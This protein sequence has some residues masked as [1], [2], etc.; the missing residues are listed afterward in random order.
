MQFRKRNS[1]DHK[2]GKFSVLALASQNILKKRCMRACSCS[3]QKVGDYNQSMPISLLP[4]K[5]TTFTSAVQ[6][7]CYRSTTQVPKQKR[8]IE[9]EADDGS[10]KRRGTTR[11]SASAQMHGW[12]HMTEQALGFSSLS[13]SSMLGMEER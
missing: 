12:D 10:I 6:S 9:A 4:F 7:G 2:N 13:M 11:N 8:E 1:L 5:A 3:S